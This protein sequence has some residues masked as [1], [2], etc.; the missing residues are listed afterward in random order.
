[1]Q[2]IQPHQ[3]ILVIDDDLVS[4]EML[5]GILSESYTVLTATGG[6]EALDLLA[7]TVPDL[8]L[9][10]IVMP[11]MDGYQAFEQIRRLPG[12]TQIPILFLTCMTEQECE[13]R[14]LELGAGDYI[15]KPYNP[16]LVRLRVRNHLQLKAQYDL[17]A[18]KN[19]ALEQKNQLQEALH[20]AQEQ[21]QASE[22][23]FRTFFD[24]ID[25][26]LFVLD[27]QGLIVKTNQT[28]VERLGYTPEELL[29]MPVLQLHPAQRRD[30][31]AGIVQQML[32]GTAQFC[33]V[34][35]LCRDGTLIPVE[36]RVTSGV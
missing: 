2:A 15:T 21:Q 5:I 27:Q 33:P 36:T 4:L 28:A 20:L 25:H 29:G 26:L 6:Q 14:G 32:A 35:L 12:L 23:N 7:R 9:L 3:S 16:H 31:A 13:L 8:I 1:M 22:D 11:E 24:T 10:D 19:R 30:E 34:P 17:I 18:E